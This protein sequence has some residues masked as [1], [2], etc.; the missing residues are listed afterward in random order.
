MKKVLMPVMILLMLSMITTVIAPEQPTVYR[1]EWDYGPYSVAECVVNGESRIVWATEEG[2][3]VVHA[4][5]NYWL[6]NYNIQF[7][8]YC[9]ETGKSLS[10]PSAGPNRFDFTTETC[11]TMGLYTK[12]QGPEGPIVL[13]AGKIVWS[14]SGENYGEVIEMHGPH[15]LSDE[16]IGDQLCSLLCYE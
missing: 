13:D 12:V 7:T 3:I 2:F 10:S 9:E 4:F 15:D 8:F 16:V 5:E 1:T 11:V 14:I 6:V